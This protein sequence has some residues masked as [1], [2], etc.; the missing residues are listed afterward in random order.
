MPISRDLSA[1]SLAAKARKLAIDS[2]Q[3]KPL[4]NVA[5]FIVAEYLFESFLR[6]G[7]T[8]LLKM[9]PAKRRSMA[10]FTAY[11]KKKSI[12]LNTARDAYR[13]VDAD[14]GSTLRRA[15]VLRRALAYAHFAR[16]LVQAP[17]ATPPQVPNLTTRAQ[18][19]EF[20]ASFSEAF[21]DSIR[22]KASPMAD[23]AAKFFKRCGKWRAQPDVWSRR[24]QR[25]LRRLRAV[26]P[27]TVKDRP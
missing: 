13:A 19:E 5:R 6:S 8:P 2:T 25:E 26:L 27:A 3:P 7:G 12:A 11:L 22:D 23:K 21:C 16:Q 24:C 1:A 17:V 9:G 4:R 10:L 20:F 18:R 15:T 14:A